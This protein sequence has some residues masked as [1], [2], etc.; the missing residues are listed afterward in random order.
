[1]VRIEDKYIGQLSLMMLY[2]KKPW[3]SYLQGEEDTCLEVL[4]TTRLLCYRTR[5]LLIC[6]PLFYHGIS[7]IRKSLG[8]VSELKAADNAKGRESSSHK[9]HDHSMKRAP[10]SASMNRSLEVSVARSML[11]AASKNK[12]LSACQESRQGR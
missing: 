12:W 4:V 8:R 10:S 6:M 11:T 3:K 5:T 7:I 2:G 9:Q 1:M